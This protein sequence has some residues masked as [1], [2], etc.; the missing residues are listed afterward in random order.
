MFAKTGL[1]IITDLIVALKE[2]AKVTETVSNKN[3]LALEEARI[4][5]G[6]VMTLASDSKQGRG[7]WFKEVNSR[8]G[9]FDG[10]LEASVSEIV[11]LEK[12]HRYTNDWTVSKIHDKC[13]DAIERLENFEPVVRREADEAR[14]GILRLLNK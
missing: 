14:D 3:D 1:E 6:G 4:K 2:V 11:H 12:E 8:V 13:I 9:Q 5:L 7:K 10:W